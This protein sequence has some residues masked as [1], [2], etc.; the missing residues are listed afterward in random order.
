MERLVHLSASSSEAFGFMFLFG[1][2]QG[3]LVFG[4]CWPQAPLKYT[5]GIDG[6]RP[7]PPHLLVPRLICPVFSNSQLRLFQRGIR[8]MQL[9]LT[10]SLPALV[11]KRFAAAKDA[12][13]LIFSQTHLEILRPGGIPVRL[14]KPHQELSSTDSLYGH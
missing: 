10:E 13:H 5:V 2:K 11:A 1:F 6:C 14:R 3:V 7:H 4:R 12:G 9:G 8:M